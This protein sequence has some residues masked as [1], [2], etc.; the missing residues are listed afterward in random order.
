MRL[1]TGILHLP[2]FTLHIAGPAD[3]GDVWLSFGGSDGDVKSVM[4]L[5]GDGRKSSHNGV[6][7]GRQVLVSAW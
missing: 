4:S 7:V 6:S 3:G 5:S 2:P 1:S